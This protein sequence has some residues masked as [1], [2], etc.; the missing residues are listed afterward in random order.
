MDIKTTNGNRV[1]YIDGN[2]IKDSSGARVCYIEG[3]DIKDSSGDRIGYMEGN[4]IKDSSGAR[5]GYMEGN[6]VKNS[7]G[8]RIGY[9]EGTASNIQKHAAGLALLKIL[10]YSSSSTYSGSA[11]SESEKPGFLGMLVAFFVSF[12]LKLGFAGKIGAL[13]GLVSMIATAIA[14]QPGNVIFLAPLGFFIGG[15]IGVFIGFIN[16]KLSRAGKLGELIGAAIIGLLAVILCIV[17]ESNVSTTLTVAIVGLIVGGIAGVII[18][19]IVGF[20]KKR[21]SHEK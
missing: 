20:I 13:I 2:V 19:S 1:G 9:I 11:S 16:R 21:I 18:G 5:I 4:D 7:S 8:D 14:T 3:N 10:S 15:G 17:T 12:F 6:D